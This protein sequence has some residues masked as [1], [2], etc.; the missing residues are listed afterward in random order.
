MRRVALLL[1][2]AAA[3]FADEPSPIEDHN[4]VLEQGWNRDG[5]AIQY[6][7]FFLSSRNAWAGELAHEWAASPRHQ[8][9][10]TIPIYNDAKTGLG[11]AM[12]NYRYQLLG[13]GESRVAVAPR[14]SLI[15][16]TRS[17]HFGERSSGVQVNVP[18]SANVTSRF[19]SHTN[20]GA[21]WFRDRGETEINLGQSFA[22]AITPHVAL[23]LDAAYTRCM[24]DP[25]LFVVRP[26]V[27][28]SF[29]LGGLK[30]SPGIGI[31]L[32]DGAGVLVY[33]ATER[34]LH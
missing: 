12:I 28:F 25:H 19:G 2:L 4:F 24:D 11:D 7:S 18:F 16:P 23:S 3:G 8:L 31:P 26:G 10:Y 1:L 29:E 22:Y 21:T 6:T 15:L 9:S 13:G 30:L 20:A 5:A 14:V 17:A 32:S 33:I 27:Q 34:A